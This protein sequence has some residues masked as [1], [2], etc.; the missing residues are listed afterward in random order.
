MVLKSICVHGH[1]YQP[2]RE[3]PLS[4]RIPDEAGAAP[5]RNWNE[6]IYSECYHPNAAQGNFQNISFNIG[7]TLF[8]WLEAYDQKTYELIIS[9]DKYNYAKYGVGNAISQPFHHV[10]LPLSSHADKVTQVQWGIADFEHRFGHKPSGMW[11]PETAVD[12]E[13]LTV[14]ADQQIKFTILAPWQINLPNKDNL[15]QPFYV[16]LPGGRKPMIIFVYHK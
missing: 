14:L 11:L 3:D 10:I 16:Q 2:P 4:D 9:Q 13:T 7:P 6:R 15:Q 8:K 1:F 5:Y 12:L